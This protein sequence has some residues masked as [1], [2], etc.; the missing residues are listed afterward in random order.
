MMTGKIISHYRVLEKL[1]GGS[2][3]DVYAAEDTNL[4]RR[5]AL[6]FLPEDVAGDP[7]ALENSK[8]DALAASVLNHP[9]I[10]A[11]H[12]FDEYEGKPFIVMELLEGETVRELLAWQTRN[13]ARPDASNHRRGRK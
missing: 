4:T 6:R 1:G 10:C 5:V 11:I 2:M 13:R 7:V 12:A 9:H 8:H 3:G